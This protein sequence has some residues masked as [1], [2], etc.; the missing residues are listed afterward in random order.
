MSKKVS[1]ELIL[2]VY[3][4]DKKFRTVGNFQ[5]RRFWRCESQI[6]RTTAWKHVFSWKKKPMSKK[7]SRGLILVVSHGDSSSRKSWIP[8]ALKTGNLKM[9]VLSSNPGITETLSHFRG[10][11]MNKWF[12]NRRSERGVSPNQV[13]ET[14]IPKL[15]IFLIPNWDGCTRLSIL[16]ETFRRALHQIF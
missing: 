9:Y 12:M 13:G 2:V 8:L 14:K 7:V 6:T 16:D 11:Q 10:K 15:A 5:N 1:R 4:G 3:P